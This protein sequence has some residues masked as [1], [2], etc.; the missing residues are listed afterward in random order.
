MKKN[1]QWKSN[2]SAKSIFWAGRST[3]IQGQICTFASKSHTF[4]GSIFISSLLTQPV[5]TLFLLT[6][7]LVRGEA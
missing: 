6:S 3:A 2:T 7:P 4:V 1:E 5:N